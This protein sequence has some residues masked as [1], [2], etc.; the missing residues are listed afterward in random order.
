RLRFFPVAVEWKKDLSLGRRVK[1]LSIPWEVVEKEAH[2]RGSYLLIL[3]LKE[4]KTLSIGKLGRINFP[5]GYYIYVGSAMA[6]LNARVERHRR[7]AKKMHWHIDYLRAESA[8][9]TVLPIRSSISLECALAERMA[10]IAEWSIPGFGSSD[11]A[12]PSH[13]FASSSNPFHLRAFIEL[14]QYFRMDR[15]TGF[16]SPKR[17]G[18]VLFTKPE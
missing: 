6:N 9:Q 18:C 10:R 13:L 3:N 1:A 17:K 16:F 2:D 12:C 5:P 15:L 14:I 7:L 4:R 8:F 11:C